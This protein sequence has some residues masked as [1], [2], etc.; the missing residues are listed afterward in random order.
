MQTL[1]ASDLYPILVEG[2]IDRDSVRGL[3]FVGNLEGFIQAAKALATRCV[4]IASRTLQESDFLYHGDDTNREQ[5]SFA[6]ADIS[7]QEANG[8][9]TVDLRAVEPSLNDYKDRLGSECGYR[10]ALHS[11]TVRLEYILHLEWWSRFSELR[12]GGIERVLHERYSAESQRR[13][14]EETRRQKIIDALRALMNDPDFVRLPTQI[15]MREYAVE[16]IADLDTVDPRIITS[17]IQSLVA[18][19]KARGLGRKK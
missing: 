4:F 6:V 10:L 9:I 12:D 7:E 13:E 16:K 18:K 14:E 3:S 1:T 8:A 2:D 17:E 19:I 15:A 11:P 5:L